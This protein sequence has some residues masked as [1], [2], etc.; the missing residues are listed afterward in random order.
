MINRAALVFWILTFVAG[1][2]FE[3]SAKTLPDSR[4][5]IP[6]AL[7]DDEK[8]W[9]ESHQTWRVAGPK[10]FPPFHFYDERG[11]ASGIAADYLH[12]LTHF[13]NVKTETTA[14]V[15]WP[16]VLKKAKAKEI[17]L[18]ALCA[19]SAAREEFLDFT[20]PFLSY[21]LVIVT[22]I[23]A[24]FISG[25]KD[26]HGKKIVF[27]KG[28]VTHDWLVRD[29]IDFTP[30]FADTPLDALKA[31][32]LGEAEAAIENLAAATHLI[33]SG[34]L[35]NLKIAAPT[36]YGQYELFMAVR[37]DWTELTLILNKA[38]AAITPEQHAEIRNRWLSVRYE[39]GI[40]KS[41]VV[42]WVVSVSAALLTLLAAFFLWN[43]RLKKEIEDR[44]KVEEALRESE[45]R[46]R[47]YIGHAPDGVLIADEKGDFIEVNQSACELTGYSEEE[48]LGK[49]IPD[50][51]QKS[52]VAKG[53]AH[54]KEVQRN[55]SAR[56][57][58]GFVTKSGENRFGQI[59]AVKLSGTRILGFF[60]D[61]TDRKRV[62]EILIASEQR[63]R[64]VLQDIPSLAV[65]GYSPD[66]TTQYWNHASEL[67]YGYT[68]RE[69]I[70]R[71]L[72]DLI[73]PPEMRGEVQQAIRMMA[74]TGR[75]IPAS[76]LALQ[77][78]DGSR[79][80]VFSSHAIVQ[81]PGKPQELF[82]IDID[83]S[84]RKRAEEALKMSEQRLAAYAAQMEQFSLSAASM[85][86]IKDENVIFAKISRAIVEFSDFRR[87][88]ISLFKEEPPYREIIGHGGVAEELVEKL[89]Q[90]HMPKSWYDNVFLQGQALGRFSYYIPHTLKHILNQ[91]ATV[92]GEGRPPENDASWHPE[93]NLFVRLND[94]NGEFIGVISVDDSKSGQKPCLETIRPLEI[95]AGLIAQI[96]I[97]KREQARREKL[98]EQ[99][100]MSQKM[101]SIGR[102]AGGVAHAFNNM[103][104]VNRGHAELALENIRLDDPLHAGLTEIQKAA[105]R[106]ADLT[107]QLLAFARKQTVAPT[108]LDLNETVE[109]ALNMLRRLIG[110]DID[111]VW[112]PGRNLDPIFIDSSQVDQ[113]LTN[114][115][116]NARD[117][118][119]DAGKIT[120]ET[121]NIVLDGEYCARHSGFSPGKYVLLTVSDS[122]CGMDAEMLSHLFE[123]FYTTKEMGKGTGL[124]L[125]MV[126]GAVKQN[127][128]F[129]SVSSEPDRGT[130]FRIYLPQYA[131]NA[132]PMREPQ[133]VPPPVTVGDTILLVEDEPAI[134]KMTT[135]MLE[136][137][138]YV[139]I[140]AGT[141]G[142]AIRLARAN[143]GQIDLLMTDVVM[144]EMNGSELA[145][146][147]MS[148]NPGIKHLFMSGYTADVIAHHGVLDEGVHFIQKPFAMKEL[149]EKL[150]EVLEG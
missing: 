13:L 56:G 61:I 20:K 70:G 97:L 91:E 142:E 40:R 124:G 74:E 41:D 131:S 43:R 77:H 133:Q 135:R 139:V 8:A 137:I 5:D 31:V 2:S 44:S 141:P 39:H 113:I 138:G 32:S 19:R 28:N 122:G 89:R 108:V 33:Q 10:A 16:D 57:E 81:T 27:V 83:I 24:Q 145:A 117:A 52:E 143:E 49:G 50:L 95:Y 67:L 36:P 103:L 71:N 96:I 144:P 54:F 51:L 99:L 115:C 14:N 98:E 121:N 84:E 112:L 38:L 30:Q 48:L 82:C 109:R 107:R 63:F 129:I 110:E 86:S 53:I 125:A 120:I 55:G 80:E 22:R 47:S 58:I 64:Q 21:P 11:A 25:I 85:I 126:Y 102:L 101:E 6:I 73:I 75:A 79:V 60:Q 105:Q 45:E 119:V 37:R 12:L 46:F 106:S 17:D 90:I 3:I 66:G 34:G 149:K 136:K 93:D 128:G 65:Q 35:A 146:N 111:L 59:A 100:L 132:A 147:L 92:Y 26:L 127:N 72:L 7:T 1:F 123:P 15:L 150:R 29:E 76:E 42:K 87:V 140:A 9:L 88:L 4:V 18:I 68:A 94:K 118:M 114:L 116:V 134:L 130:T 69:A 62:E 23:D 104:S 78:K 148:N